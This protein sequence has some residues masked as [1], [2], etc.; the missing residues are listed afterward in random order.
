MEGPWPCLAWL[1]SP[2]I[3][4]ARLACTSQQQPGAPL[5]LLLVQARRGEPMRGEVSQARPGLVHTTHVLLGL[6]RL[7]TF[8]EIYILKKRHYGLTFERNPLPGSDSARHLE[9]DAL[10]LV[11]FGAARKKKVTHMLTQNVPGPDCSW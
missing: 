1:T 6:S 7:D 8:S 3:G 2:R 5:L 4:L 9:P 10:I 11:R